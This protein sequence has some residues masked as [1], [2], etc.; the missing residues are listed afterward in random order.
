MIKVIVNLNVSLKRVAL[1]SLSLP[2][3]LYGV[4]LAQPKVTSAH[5]NAI[6]NRPQKA[7]PGLSNARLL[8]RCLRQI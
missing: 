3:G 6:K 4:F 2:L 5:N 1:V 8:L 7:W